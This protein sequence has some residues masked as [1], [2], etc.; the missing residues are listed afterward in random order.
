MA[1]PRV[2]E[3]SNLLTVLVRTYLFVGNGQLWIICQCHC[4]S[5]S[6]KLGL[7]LGKRNRESIEL[8]GAGIVDF[9]QGTPTELGPTLRQS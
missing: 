2:N 4:Q 5:D 3:L 1:G 8:L 7:I 9:C 6:H